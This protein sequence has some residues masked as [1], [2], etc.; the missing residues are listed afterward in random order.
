[1][2]TF[3]LSLSVAALLFS[4]YGRRDG[5]TTRFVY[6]NSWWL[7]YRHLKGIEIR[8]VNTR[9]AIDNHSLFFPGKS[10]PAGIRRNN[11]VLTDVTR[12]GNRR[13]I[14]LTV[15]PHD[16]WSVNH[17]TI[18]R[19]V[20]LFCGKRRKSWSRLT[21]WSSASVR[22]DS[23]CSARHTSFDWMIMPKEF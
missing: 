8:L 7:L 16:G 11:S 4:P 5:K 21:D 19:S 9:T 20:S 1:M 15:L 22:D 2:I 18:C 6:F 14:W 10:S 13:T 23:Y 3:P 12:R 17:M